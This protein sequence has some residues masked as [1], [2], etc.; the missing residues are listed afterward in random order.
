M[1]KDV[2]KFTCCLCG[3]KVAE[4]GNNPAPLAGNKC[5]NACDMNYVIPVR[6]FM[7]DLA[8]RYESETTP[9]EEFLKMLHTIKK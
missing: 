6:E 3:K 5:C 4:Y 9:Y 2:K 1:N 7:S 8:E